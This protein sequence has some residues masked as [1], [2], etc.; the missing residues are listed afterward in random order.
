[1]HKILEYPFV[2]LQVHNSIAQR[3]SSMADNDWYREEGILKKK[4]FF[5]HR[6]AFSGVRPEIA[7]PLAAS[8]KSSVATLL[9]GGQL[10][11]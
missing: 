11:V 1:M 2:R 6:L 3:V 10:F 8:W 5:L 9:V 4:Q 7:G